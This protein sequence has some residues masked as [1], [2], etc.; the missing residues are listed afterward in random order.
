MFWVATNSCCC[1]FK[2]KWIYHRD[3]S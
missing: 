2:K 3:Y 1:F